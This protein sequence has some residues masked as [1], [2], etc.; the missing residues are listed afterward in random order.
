MTNKQRRISLAKGIFTNKHWLETQDGKRITPK[1]IIENAEHVDQFVKLDTS[2]GT[3]VYNEY[4]GSILHQDATKAEGVKVYKFADNIYCIEFCMERVGCCCQF[5]SPNG[6]ELIT[7][8][9]TQVHKINDSLIAVE[10]AFEGWGFTDEKLNWIVPPKYQEFYNDIY[11]RTIA[12]YDKKTDIITI[13]PA[14]GVQIAQIDGLFVKYMSPE[15]VLITLNS[16]RFGLAKITGELIAPIKYSHVLKKKIDGNDY[17]VVQF[18]G[19][20]GLLDSNG[21][22]CCECIYHKIE[23]KD[24]KVVGIKRQITEISEVISSETKKE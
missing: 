1:F 17:Y 13:E 8:I 21:N 2:K 4:C 5:F 12:C 22:T 7:N 19:C 23:I 16:K 14:N 24:G 18:D 15:I 3:F 6:Q 10:D 9:V 20:Y 11:G